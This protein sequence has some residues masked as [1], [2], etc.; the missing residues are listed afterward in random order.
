M[1]FNSI[2][3]IIEELKEGKMVVMVDDEDRENEGDLIISASFVTSE[4]INF[5]AK[6][7]RGLICV[8]MEG[9]RLDELGLHPMANEPQD[10]YK[11]AWTISVDAKRN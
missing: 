5:M 6:Y 7:G 4:H 8:P 11:T 2:E 3:E 9:K 10:P 1:K